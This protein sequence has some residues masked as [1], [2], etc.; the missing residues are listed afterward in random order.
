MLDDVLDTEVAVDPVVV[1]E[2]I[3]HLT[4]HVII[5][6]T[7]RLLKNVSL[8]VA[9]TYLCRLS[10]PE[11]GVVLLPTFYRGATQWTVLKRHAPLSC[12]T[13]TH[14]RALPAPVR[15]C[16]TCQ[17]PGEIRQVAAAAAS[18]RSPR[19]PLG[20]P[21][22][23]WH[24]RAVGQASTKGSRRR[25]RSSMVMSCRQTQTTCVQSV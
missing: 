17:N 14:G 19:A 12:R 10:F 15:G 2:Q 11:C 7:T 3:P 21:A 13:R 1:V 9:S 8:N 18:S 25:R 16:W 22:Q 23:P 6:E 24:R 4:G 5:E 20:Q